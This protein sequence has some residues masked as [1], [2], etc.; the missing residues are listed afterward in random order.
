MFWSGSLSGL[1]APEKI[2]LALQELFPLDLS[3][4]V[5]FLEHLD[6]ALRLRADW[7][8]M[9]WRARLLMVVPG[10]ASYQKDDANDYQGENCKHYYHHAGV[11]GVGNPSK[12]SNAL[13]R[14]TVAPAGDMMN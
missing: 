3:A 4:G 12:C 7:R 8:R 11:A 13:E 1:L 10:Q 14:Y 9:Q 5:A 6:R 2:L